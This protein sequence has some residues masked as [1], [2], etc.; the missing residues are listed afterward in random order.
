MNSQRARN[1]VQTVV[2]DAKELSQLKVTHLDSRTSRRCQ[3]N[4][5][6]TVAAM[7]QLSAILL[8]FCFLRLANTSPAIELEDVQ[9]LDKEV[10]ATKT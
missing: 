2:A 3:A 6:V 7:T 5:T 4:V 9:Y 8:S 1:W 10:S